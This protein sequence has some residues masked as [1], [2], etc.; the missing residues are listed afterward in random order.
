M[1][2]EGAPAAERSGVVGTLSQPSAA[3]LPS[4][5]PKS[6]AIRGPSFRIAQQSNGAQAERAPLGTRLTVPEGGEL[7]VDLANGARLRLESGSRA[8]LLDAEPAT[9]VFLHGAVHA[10]LPPQGSAAGRAALRIV[11]VGYALSVP[12]AAE[13]WLA[14][15]AAVS[16][17]TDAR[18]QYLAVLSGTADLEQL[19]KDDT[20][21]VATK[22]L[23]AEQTFGG[24][25]P[26]AA[27]PPPA[28]G[29]SS[30]EQ[31]R[32]AYAGMRPPPKQPPLA[33]PVDAEAALVRALDAWGHALERGRDLLTAQREALAKG[34]SAA[35]QTAQRDLVALA[36]QKLGLRQRVRLTF[37]L[38][39]ER[40]LA[41]LGDANSDLASFEARYATRVAP[42]LPTAGL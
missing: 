39:C 19:G 9:L 11:T 38:A 14:G 36:Q 40:A 17:R 42:A 35:V 15:P 27:K 26:S 33:P 2:H 1:P 32:S 25:T 7:V 30:I 10:Q 28:R 4:A 8:W 23:L 12:I 3:A 20:G 22:Q 29:P 31:A 37:E 34:D 24:S 16:G 41:Q 5:E 6:T 13:L 18:A 21:P